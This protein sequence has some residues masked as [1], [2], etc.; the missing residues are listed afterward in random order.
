[1]VLECF[2]VGDDLFQV[3][4]AGSVHEGQTAYAYVQAGHLKEVVF[5]GYF[6]GW[7]SPEALDTTRV[8]LPGGVRVSGAV[9]EACA[10][11][12]EALCAAFDGGICQ[13]K[14]A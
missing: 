3:G 14:R 5:G 13:I 1:V 9:Y 11:E 2:E 4:V 12:H 8:A 6:T 10:G 7:I